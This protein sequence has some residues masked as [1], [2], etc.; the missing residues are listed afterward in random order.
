MLLT[1]YKQGVNQQHPIAIKDL[2]Y[3][4]IYYS[5]R[6]NCLSKRLNCKPYRSWLKCLDFGFGLLSL[7]IDSHLFT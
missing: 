3:L 2:D 1:I 7:Q 4:L 5:S 6:N